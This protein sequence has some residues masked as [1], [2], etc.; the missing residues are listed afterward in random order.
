MHNSPDDTN[1]PEML[2]D[3]PEAIERGEKQP[4]LTVYS[5]GEQWYRLDGDQKI[6]VEVFED[7]EGH[8]Y[9]EIEGT[10]DTPEKVYVEKSGLDISYLDQADVYGFG[11]EQEADNTKDPG[12]VDKIRTTTQDITPQLQEAAEQPEDSAERTSGAETAFT[13]REAGLRN[14]IAE[15]DPNIP[16]N[17]EVSGAEYK[18][19]LDHAVEQV[20]QQLG[21]ELSDLEAMHSV[22][23]TE[24]MALAGKVEEL[25][26]KIA[27]E[28]EGATDDQGLVSK[29]TLEKVQSA[30]LEGNDYNSIE[31]IRAT[32]DGTTE[33]FMEATGMIRSVAD[34]MALASAQAV[35]RTKLLEN[36][37]QELAT[38]KDDKE[39]HAVLDRLSEEVDANGPELVTQL[40]LT[41]EHGQEYEV[42]A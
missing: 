4:Q 39:A 22:T 19:K 9:I 29:E 34:I 21:Y 13:Q 32:V 28:M 12:K 36:A 11:D 8:S 41:G 40:D 1:N 38:A 5:D 25:R 20:T 33:K 17:A 27:T 24:K 35:A 15:V 31:K 2:Q 37:K 14:T 42:A 10:D 16:Q 26:G 23:G 30:F 18:L 7:E 3:T 6:P